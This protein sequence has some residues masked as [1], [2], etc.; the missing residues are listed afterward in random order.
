MQA[1]RSVPASEAEAQQA[2]DVARVRL[3]DPA[4]AQ[5]LAADSAAVE[6]RFGHRGDA[7]TAS[8]DA[9]LQQQDSEVRCF[10][11]LGSEHSKL[12]GWLS[13]SRICASLAWMVI[14]GLHGERR[15]WA[16]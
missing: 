11:V 4:A 13:G 10:T 7:M 12:S 8:L 1:G 5:D 6:A 15:C 9:C 16:L 2:L 14:E 3:A